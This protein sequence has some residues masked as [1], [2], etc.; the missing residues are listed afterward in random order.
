MNHMKIPQRVGE[1]E[2]KNFIQ[3]LTAKF[4]E[5]ELL[6]I[7]FDS[8]RQQLISELLA[9]GTLEEKKSRLIS[10]LT[11]QNRKLHES[12][13]LSLEREEL[14]AHEF[15]LSIICKANNKLMEVVFDELA[16]PFFKQLIEIGFIE[17][18]AVSSSSKVS[19]C[20]APLYSSFH[21]SQAQLSD[22]L[23]ISSSDAFIEYVQNNN[24]WQL[25]YPLK[26]TWG[27]LSAFSCRDAL[28]SQFIDSAASL[29]EK[30]RFESSVAAA[31]K[32]GKK[33]KL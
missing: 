23:A 16:N 8:Q 9:P 1:E 27:M 10:S 21:I 12:M 14:A 30:E 31:E 3:E 18:P 19:F 17:K 25:Y 26:P 32:Q 20:I 33:V 7:E 2:S 15:E 5:L 22:F 4:K 28:I 6:A 24:D 13:F 29:I 11:C